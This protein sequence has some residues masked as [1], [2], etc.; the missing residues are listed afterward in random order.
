MNL[1]K[2][3]ACKFILSRH[4][5]VGKPIFKGKDGCMSFFHRVC[6]VQYDPVD[7]CGRNADIVLNS[8]VEGYK[9]EYLYALLYQDRKLIDCFDKNLAISPIENFSILRNE[10]LNSGDAGAYERNVT[11][12]VKG[13]MPHIRRLIKERGHISSKE[14]DMGEKIPWFWGH[15]TSLSRAAL[16]YMY[17]S[18]ELVV[19]HK[20]GTNKSYAL[21]EDYIPA[22][23]LNISMPFANEEERLAWHVKRRI[24]GVGMLWNRASDAFLGLRLKSTQRGLA[25][26]KLLK[27]GEIFEI[28]VE[29][30]KDS[31]YICEDERNTLESILSGP[32]KGTSDASRTEFIAPLDSLMWDRKLIYALFG[33]EYKWEIYTPKVKRKYGPYTLP[34]LHQGEFMGRIDVSRK[35][36][37]LIV[38]NIWMENNLPLTGDVKTAI[39]ACIQRFAAFNGCQGE[40]IY[41]TKS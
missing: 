25:F 15:Q 38:N 18:G 41:A 28:N 22:E 7:V 11:D 40:S 30:L 6:C 34:I 35:G 32:S 2:E 33:F 5:L 29:G 1:T 3:Q 13:A 21:T 24:S 9:K 4:G 27:D 19:H 23:I 36:R 39:D 10:R 37:E 26:A 20:K 16:E 14:V 8:R 31:L 12:A 17:F